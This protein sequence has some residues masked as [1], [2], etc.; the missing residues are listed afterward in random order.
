MM[1]GHMESIK[2]HGICITTTSYTLTNNR[3]NMRGNRTRKIMQTKNNYHSS[4]TGTTFNAMP[5]H[6][7]SDS[8]CSANLVRCSKYATRSSVVCSVAGTGG[9]SPLPNAKPPAPSGGGAKTDA[10]N[11]IVALVG[12]LPDAAPYPRGGGRCSLV[13]CEGDRFEYA[14]FEGKVIVSGPLADP[15]ARALSTKGELFMVRGGGL[16]EA[17]GERRDCIVKGLV[18]RSCPLYCARRVSREAERNWRFDRDDEDDE[19]TARLDPGRLDG[20]SSSPFEADAR[21][22]DL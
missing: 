5:S 4:T 20:R 11:I 17:K 1:H 19:E 21:S 12:A 3:A 13:K 7:K 6:M 9:A 15:A 16:T 10:S 8:R 2:H 14:K 18:F 22:F